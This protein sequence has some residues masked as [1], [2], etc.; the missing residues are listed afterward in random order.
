MLTQPT[1]T[2]WAISDLHVGFE[3]NRQAVE[4]LPAYPGDWLILGGD[5]G[6]TAAQ[7]QLVLDVVTA[8]FAKVIWVPGNHDL[9]TPRQWPDANRGVAHYER[10]VRLFA[11]KPTAR[12]PSCLWDGKPVPEGATECWQN[13]TLRCAAA[14]WS[15]AGVTPAC[16]K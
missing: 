1:A 16:P 8:R 5:T 2:L 4:A 9:W 3:A 15:T 11:E 12:E 14:G 7:L 10:L 6:D 13:L